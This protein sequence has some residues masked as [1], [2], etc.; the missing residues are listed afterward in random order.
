MLKSL[1]ISLLLIFVCYMLHRT[2][3]MILWRHNSVLYHVTLFGSLKGSCLCLSLFFF[4]FLFVFDIQSV[5]E[6]CPLL[7]A[8]PS[9]NF[10]LPLLPF[11]PHPLPSPSF[12]PPLPPRTNYDDYDTTI[13]LFHF[14][15]VFVPFFLLFFSLKFPLIMFVCLFFSY[16]YYYVFFFGFLCFQPQL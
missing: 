12:P 2:G 9:W 3:N 16:H 8:P 7:V 15:F 1:N 10:H 5:H 6:V 14:S 4:F 13:V 11:T